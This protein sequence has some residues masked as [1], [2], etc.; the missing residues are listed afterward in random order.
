MFIQ[1]HLNGYLRGEE[2]Y[3]NVQRRHNLATIEATP[4]TYKQQACRT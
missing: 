3:V 4:Y 2:K 1:A